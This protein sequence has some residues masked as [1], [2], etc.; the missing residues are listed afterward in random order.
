M[1]NKFLFLSVGV[2]LLGKFYLV[3]RFAAIRRK[4]EEF[5]NILLVLIAL[6]YGLRLVLWFQ[7]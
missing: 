7:S 3:P 6:V 4:F 5:I 1:L 2:L